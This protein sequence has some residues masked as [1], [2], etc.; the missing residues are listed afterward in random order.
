MRARSGPEHGANRLGRGQLREGR[1][2]LLEEGGGLQAAFSGMCSGE[3]EE[4]GREE[5]IRCRDQR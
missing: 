4:K 1:G 2:S 5:S 3:P